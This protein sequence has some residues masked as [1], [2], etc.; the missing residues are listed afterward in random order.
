MKIIHLSDFNCPY[1]YIGL[2]RIANACAELDL[3]VEWEM[4][5]FELEPNIDSISTVER[6]AI[7]NGL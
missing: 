1:S 6:F 7:K 2:K 5:S 4:V 3:D